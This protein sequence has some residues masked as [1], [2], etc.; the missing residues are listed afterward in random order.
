MTANQMQ[1]KP[2]GFTLVELLV[3]II[4]VSLLSALML[5]GLRAASARN[6]VAATE[7]FINKLSDAIFERYEAYED[8][9]GPETIFQLRERLAYELPDVWADVQ[10]GS[11]NPLARV[12]HRY[13]TNCTPDTTYESAECLY[14]IVTQSGYFQ[15]VVETIHASQ[16]GDVDNDGAPEFLDSWKRPI[17]FFRWA[18]GY[19]SARYAGTAFELQNDEVVAGV[20]TVADFFDVKGECPADFSMFPLIYSGGPD[21]AMGLTVNSGGWLAKALSTNTNI[22]QYT[23]IGSSSGPA[24]NDNI[25]NHDLFYE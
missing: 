11:A 16:I 14:M 24:A 12:Y 18:P 6:N 19:V 20:A 3:V 23:N 13:K 25:T 1:T 5:G 9:V 4:I 21:Q 10:S 17:G 22:C 15:D 7:F 8:L 2:A